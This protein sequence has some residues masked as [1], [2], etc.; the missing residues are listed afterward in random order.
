MDKLILGR[1]IPGNSF[2]HRLDPRSKLL[3]MMVFIV[4]VF[5]GNNV[6]TNGLMLAFTLLAILLS[7]IPLT[8][9]ING[10]KPMIGIILFTTLFQVFFTQQGTPLISFWIIKITDFGL[11]QAL[12]ISCAGTL[13]I[14]KGFNKDSTAS[15]KLSG[16]G[17]TGVVFTQLDHQSSKSVPLLN[18]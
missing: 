12:L 10:V 13:K 6:L 15:A 5:W 8:F 7:K 17:D 1:Y 9:F 11:A 18:N 4:V 16:I 14:R 2:V 3:A